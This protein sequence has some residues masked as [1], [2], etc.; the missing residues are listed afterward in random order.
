[1]PTTPMK[2]RRTVTLPGPEPRSRASRA[3]TLIELLAVIA[4]IAVLAAL[5]LPVLGKA[6]ETGRAAACI[7]NLR[8]LGIALSA[9]SLDSKGHLPDFREWL[10]LASG[11]SEDLTT[12]R[13]YP[14]L[15][16]KPVYLCPTDRLALSAK[17]AAP[18]S[19]PRDYSYAMNCVICH[20]TDT[21]KFVTPARTLLLGEAELK[22]NDY[23][24]LVGP[25]P[26]MGSTSVISSRHNGRAHL[27]FCDSHV[28]R[29][30]TMTAKQLMR[31]KSFWLPCPTS[32]P[33]S[34]T[35]TSGLPDP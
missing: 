11:S 10:R 8:Q 25:S 22:W 34:L 29:V 13:L 7:S 3:F 28:E 30:K 35:F 27:M 9:Y 14:Y 23:T 19:K 15:K 33:I 18:G 12:G 4:I 17:T 1:M 31:S 6:K 24:G 32:D 5:L 2:M 26:W 20:D 21:A 16:S